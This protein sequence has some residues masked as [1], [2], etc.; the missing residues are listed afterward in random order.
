[1]NK[2]KLSKKKKSCARDKWLLSVTG[3]ASLHGDANETSEMCDLAT[4]PLEGWRGNA[5][6]GKW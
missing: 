4:V 6:G 1:V 3:I 5:D 2:D